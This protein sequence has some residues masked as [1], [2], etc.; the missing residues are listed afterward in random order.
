MREA[1]DLGI[2]WP[3]WHTLM[4]EEQALDMRVICPQD[5]KNMLLKHARM[6]CWKKW[7]TKH[8]YEELK[9]GIRLELALALLREKTKEGWTE[10][11]RNVARR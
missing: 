8:E 3:Q 1:R 6:V 10:K 4:F 2:K 7:A 9:E 11:H 5:V